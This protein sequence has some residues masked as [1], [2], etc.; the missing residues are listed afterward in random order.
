MTL[1]WSV[2]AYISKKDSSGTVTFDDSYPQKR[3]EYPPLPEETKKQL[4]EILE[5]EKDDSI[6]NI[7]D[8]FEYINRKIDKDSVTTIEYA[9][10]ADDDKQYTRTIHHV[11]SELDDLYNSWRR[12]G[13]STYSSECEE[14]MGP[15]DTSD[16]PDYDNKWYYDIDNEVH[17]AIAATRQ[18][19][20]SEQIGT[21]IENW[22]KVQQLLTERKIHYMQEGKDVTKPDQN[23]DTSFG[24][25]PLDGLSKMASRMSQSAMS[26]LGV[27]K[28][29]NEEIFPSL[30][31]KYLEHVAE[32]HLNPSKDADESLLKSYKGYW[33]EF[34]EKK[35]KDPQTYDPMSTDSEFVPLLCEFIQ[36][37]GSGMIDCI[38]PYLYMQIRVEEMKTLDVAMPHKKRSG[39]SELVVGTYPYT[40]DKLQGNKYDRILASWSITAYAM[41]N[42][43]GEEIGQIWE[44]TDRLLKRGGIATFYPIGH[45]GNSTEQIG[46]IIE[47]Y[48]RKSDSRIT[49]SFH[50]SGDPRFP[51]DD[52]LVIRKR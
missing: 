14:W 31:Y 9:P 10:G 43:T 52:V 15:E 23:Y 4:K 22:R 1:E 3:T 51:E 6:L 40:K 38:D 27:V 26:G 18:A 24:L 39:Q 48:I 45:Y 47:E 12:P 30:M 37:H 2:S 20:T 46:K 49:Y 28:V 21:A 33:N 29:E 7:G 16:N 13:Y 36:S 8:P 34:L 19:K 50:K 44:E 11:E 17:N 25:S 42:M 5:R 32:A 41:P 35:G